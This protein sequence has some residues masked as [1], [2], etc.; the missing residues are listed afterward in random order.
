M[1]TSTIFLYFL[2]HT[3]LCHLSFARDWDVLTK[4]KQTVKYALVVLPCSTL[5]W[6]KGELK[7]WNSSPFSFWGHGWKVKTL[8]P[9]SPHLS[10][11]TI[12]LFLLG[13]SFLDAIVVTEISRAGLTVSVDDHSRKRSFL[14]NRSF[15]TAIFP[16]LSICI[17]IW[18]E[19]PLWDGRMDRVCVARQIQMWSRI[20]SLVLN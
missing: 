9:G 2:F 8:W 10:V 18:W 7:G 16:I 14:A 19:H 6:S 4:R 3:W 15:T 1:V 17:S 5:F 11:R 20:A 13:W 12:F